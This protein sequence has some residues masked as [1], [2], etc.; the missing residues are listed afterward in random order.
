MS[1]DNYMLIRKVGGRYR[2]SMQSASEDEPWLEREEEFATIEEALAR[3]N[4]EPV[5]EYGF[6]YEDCDA[7]KG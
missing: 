5:L 4:E 6:S 3:V 1:A 2:V 7:H